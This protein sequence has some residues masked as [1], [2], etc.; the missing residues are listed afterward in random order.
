[1]INKEQ[2]RDLITY[3]L[4]ELELATD[5]KIKMSKDAV[6]LLMMTCAHES[7]LGTYIKQIKGPALGIFQMEPRTHD[8]IWTN[9]IFNR[10]WLEDAIFNICGKTITSSNLKYDLKYAT[11]MARIHYYRVPEGLPSDPEGYARYAK[12]YYNTE[13]GAATEADYFNAYMKLGY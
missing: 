11:L 5:G 12:K 1:M 6:E 3:T 10:D 13:L 8:D 4:E 2:L 7:K 9:Y